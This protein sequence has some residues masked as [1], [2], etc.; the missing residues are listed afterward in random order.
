MPEDMPLSTPPPDRPR[1]FTRSFLP[2]L[3]ALVVI[4]GLAYGGRAFFFN[5]GHKHSDA[6]QGAV[7][8]TCPMHPAIIDSRPGKCPIC[9][10][11]LVKIENSSAAQQLPEAAMA[12]KEDLEDLFAD[13]PDVKAQAV[14][15]M[16]IIQVGN[17]SL[18]LSGVQTAEAKNEEVA[19]SVRTVG[20][21][22][23]DETRIRHVHTKIAGWIETLHTNF[24]GQT[25]T[26][27]Q[28]LLSIYSPEL[29]STQEE[30]LAARAAALKF[31]SSSSP[32]VKALGQDLLRSSRKRLTLFDVPEKVITDLELTGV[33]QRTVTLDA[34]VSGFV[35][36]KGIYE[37]QQ[38][39]PGLE[40]FTIT[41]LS[42]VWIEADLYEYEAGA[43]RIGQEAT[44]SLAYEPGTEL[45]G[46]VA[47]VSPYL[48]SESRTLKVRFDFPNPDMK[49]KPQMYADVTLTLATG[50]GVSIPDSAVIDSGVRQV[51]FVKTGAD[52][53]EPREVKGGVRGNGRVQILAGVKAGERVVVKANFLLDSES[54]LRSALSKMTG[55]GGK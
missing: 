45:K 14:E 26:K 27:D 12:K 28:P 33:V 23:S 53:F 3:L 42:H 10:M 38:V 5:A 51:V 50:G 25:V 47:Y 18:K 43:V 48:S 7:K 1:F 6:D 41:D 20:I 29:L 31:A 35:T 55:G 40:L 13:S 36:A 4:A 34:P 15:G 9:G 19:R 44:L 17:E 22:V 39:E 54:R 32:D 46:T 49:L 2:L 52:T 16:T 21:V 30:F 37:G 24:T 8:Y 11:D